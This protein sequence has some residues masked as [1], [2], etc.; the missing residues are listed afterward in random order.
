MT[1][2]LRS[3]ALLWG[4]SQSAA[5]T[6]GVFGDGVA[7]QRSVAT[8]QAQPAAAPSCGVV[9]DSVTAERGSALREQQPTASL[10]SVAD[11]GVAA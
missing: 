8:L 4:E 1:V 6:R 7:R 2:L 11:D 3:S 10:G 5:L 9:R